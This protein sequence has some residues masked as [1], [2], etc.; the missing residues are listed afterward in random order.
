M[1]QKQSSRADHKRKADEQHVGVDGSLLSKHP[2]LDEPLQ[3]R[4]QFLY[5]YKDH[6]DFVR[7]TANTSVSDELI[8]E[9]HDLP[10]NLGV[11]GERLPCP[12][13]Y[14]A[15]KIKSH[16]KKDKEIWSY[17]ESALNPTWTWNRFEGDSLDQHMS[18]PKWPDDFGRWFFFNWSGNPS[19]MW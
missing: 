11:N 3:E 18:D 12:P 6:L 14:I 15:E 8:K 19:I 17:M 7:L 10:W 5:K 2:R 13:E 9:T 16:T 4:A 1:D